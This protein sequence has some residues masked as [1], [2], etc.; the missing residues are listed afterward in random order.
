MISRQRAR[1]VCNSRNVPGR[2]EKLSSAAERNDLD[3]NDR[4][5]KSE[6]LYPQIAASTIDKIEE[7]SIG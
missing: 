3:A 6:D 2:S 7:I 4:R 5:A 1:G